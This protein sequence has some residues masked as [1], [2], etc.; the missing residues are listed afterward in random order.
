MESVDEGVS[1]RGAVRWDRR[2]CQW[3]KPARW[4]A[5]VVRRRRGDALRGSR[6]GRSRLD[7]ELRRGA[8]EHVG[9][10]REGLERRVCAVWEGGC[11]GGLG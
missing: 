11:E 5:Q 8:R 4:R 3:R 7:D 10:S 6:N 2:V 9:A 1:W